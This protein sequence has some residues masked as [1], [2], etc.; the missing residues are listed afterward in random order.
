[1]IQIVPSDLSPSLLMPFNIYVKL[2]SHVALSL[3][4]ASIK[5]ASTSNCSALLLLILSPST[6]AGCMFKFHWMLLRAKGLLG[7]TSSTHQSWQ[8]IIPLH[9]EIHFHRGL[10]P[11]VP[12]RR[13]EVLSAHGRTVLPLRCN[14]MKTNP[15]LSLLLV[16]AFA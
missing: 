3:F 7:M 4:A 5:Y 12:F 2:T 14:W 13:Q 16:Q 9:V 11:K 1:M 15:E 10:E 8:L 6:L